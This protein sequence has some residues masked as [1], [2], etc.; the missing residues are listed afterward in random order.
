[1]KE[2]KYKKCFQFILLLLL[3]LSTQYFAQSQPYEPTW[4][5]LA[6]H[7][8][9][10]WYEDAVLGIYFHWGVYSVPGFGC[11][12]GRNMYMPDGGNSENWGHIDR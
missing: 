11:W 7:E 10:H 12:G 6:N 5:S 8:T 2:R 1:M 4:E 9:P 3:F